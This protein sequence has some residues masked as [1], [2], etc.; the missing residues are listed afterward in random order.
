MVVVIGAHAF[1]YLC[2]ATVHPIRKFLRSIHHFN[3][4]SFSQPFAMVNITVNIE[5]VETE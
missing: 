1:P 5:A 2:P 3:S 4:I